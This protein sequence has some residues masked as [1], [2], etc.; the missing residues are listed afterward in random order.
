MAQTRDTVEL[1]L[2]LTEFSYVLNKELQ[3]RIA[4][5]PDE[6]VD[7]IVMLLL[8]IEGPKR[9]TELRKRTRLSSGGMTKVIDR[10][11]AAGLVSRDRRAIDNDNRAVVIELTAAGERT[12]ESVASSTVDIISSEPELTK[13][14][15][16][17][18]EA[19]T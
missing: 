11:E 9:P 2:G 12:V 13:M 4:P 3:S 5:L 17:L 7:L 8:S 18:F 14:I 16:M 19:A 6:N 10:L 15:L 1:L